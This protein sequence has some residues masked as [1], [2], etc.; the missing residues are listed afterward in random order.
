MP[1]ETTGPTEPETGT[2]EPLHDT[3]GHAKNS[4]HVRYFTLG[5][6]YDFAG[7]KEELRGYTQVLLGREAPPIDRGILTL[8]E[9]AE[10]YHARAKE[11]EMELLELEAEGAV[12]RGSRPYKFRTG[13]LRSFIEMCSKTI[14]LGSRRM[15]QAVAEAEGKA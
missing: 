4:G 8:M 1:M 12:L 2:P 15:T 7:M 6:G 14:D 9:L 5:D 11:I 3:H 10:A 13:M